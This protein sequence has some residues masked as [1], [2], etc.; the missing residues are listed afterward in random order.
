VKKMFWLCL[1]SFVFS[2]SI[3]AMP[4]SELLPEER[5][6]VEL[7]QQYAANVVYVHRLATYVDNRYQT[8]DVAAGSG[9]G[10]IW[11][12]EGHVVTNFHVVKGADKLVIS[13][14]HVTL[15]AR[16]IGVEPFRDIA[17]LKI[18]VKKANDAL[19]NVKPFV[20]APTTELLVGQKAV[21]IGNPFGLDH[22]LT[23][24]VISAVGR[25]V[26]G[27]GGV[28]IRN[29]IQT[30]ASIN[31]GNSGGPLLDSR[32]RLIGL[33]TV[34]YSN[35]GSSS[36]VGFAVPAD[37]IGRLVPQ[38]IKNGRVIMAG[39]GISRINP[40]VA[41]S[42]GVHNGVLIGEVLPNTP[43]ASAGLR[44]THRAAWGGIQLGDIIVGFNGHPVA[45]YD[46]L[47]S[48]F[49]DVKVGDEVK[50]SVLRDKQILNFKLK[51]I[52]IGS[53]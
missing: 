24:G 30:D 50:L 9:S 36:G 52:D 19:Q 14:G 15:P 10:I 28:T 49:S 25:Q 51:T 7:F 17:V 42:L 13:I 43:A 27:A 35:S 1:S 3:Q 2:F 41:T 48:Y 16:V 32:G 45:N 44:G 6:T 23:V 33:N 29:M 40:S 20:L 31:P 5:N 47:Y 22:S 8:Y 46:V 34:I 11:D 21:A 12:N 53:Y 18:D 4:I 38:L 26:P 37:D 39:I